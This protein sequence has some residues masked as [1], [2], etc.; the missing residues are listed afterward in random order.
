MSTGDAPLGPREF[1]F[2][3]LS[4]KQFEFLCQL[5]VKTEFP[6]AIGTGD[7]D[8][9]ADSLLAAPDG[10]W[11]R[12]WQ[13]KRF[14]GQIRWS[15]CRAS[16]NDAIAEYQ[17]KH[18][19]FCFAR[20]LTVT[21]LRGWR[22]LQ[23]DYPQLR[24]DFWDKVYLTALLIGS[25][26]GQRIANAFFGPRPPSAADINRILRAGALLETSQDALD[27]VI[28]LVEQAAERDPHYAYTIVGYEPGHEAPITPGT[29]ISVFDLRGGAGSRIDAIPRSHGLAAT[30]PPTLKLTFDDD[31]RGRRAAA[32]F[33]QAL[34]ADDSTT[35]SEGLVVSP[36]NLPALFQDQIGS[37]HRASITLTPQP[38]PPWEIVCEAST[39]RG[40]ASLPV[41]LRRVRGESEE[42][43]LRMVGTRSGVTLQLEVRPL[44]EMVRLGVN[45]S[46]HLDDSTLVEHVDALR[47]MSV[48]CGTGTVTI[49]D[50]AGRVPPLVSRVRGRPFEADWI[51]ELLEDMVYVQTIAGMQF[52]MPETITGEDAAWFRR[53]AEVLRTGKTILR[54][55]GMRITGPSS[56]PLPVTEGAV[57]IEQNITVTLLGHEIDLGR[58]VLN[59]P[60]VELVDQGRLPEDPAQRIVELRPPGGEPDEA[61]WQ[62]KSTATS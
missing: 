25:D 56:N 51:L 14:T 2:A 48:V 9:G 23:D 10:S 59:L 7:P 18:M 42:P 38:P 1:D 62:A 17:I 32:Q 33:E 61:E 21:R 49:R 11:E 50:A 31:E 58:G 60:R 29:A 54:W 45:F 26:Q 3:Q 13:A 28:A 57:R 16:V 47:F 39:D 55:A 24:L 46:H 4:P 8:G 20:Q 22:E 41:V 27:R 44:G 6:D 43:V 36:S 12:G 40:S 5:V 37:P 19:T 30:N 52:E 34:R 35:I 15:Q 53:V